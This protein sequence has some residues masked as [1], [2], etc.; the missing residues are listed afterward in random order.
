MLRL[1]RQDAIENLSGF[2]FTRISLVVRHHSSG[3][4][5]E[6]IKDRRFPV[7]RVALIKL[8]HRL[9]VGK[10]AC[11]MIDLVSVFV[12]SVQRCDVTRIKDENNDGRADVYQVVSNGW[13]ITGDYHEYAFGSKFD[14]AGYLWV[15]LCLTGSFSSEALFRG[16][17]LRVSADGTTLPTC[18]GL[19]SPGGVGANA[20]GDM[21]YTD[22]QGPWN[23]ACSLKWLRPGAFLGH[24]IDRP[25]AP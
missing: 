6:R 23:G 12:K 20:A 17:C 8:L 9:V 13:G 15:P 18:S 4:Q 19:R 21:F 2:F 25:T 3:D 5:R 14:N 16:W 22:N 10:R 11:S 24:P 7:G 1:T